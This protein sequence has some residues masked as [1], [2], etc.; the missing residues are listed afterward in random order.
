MKPR[1]LAIRDLKAAGYVFD[2]HG[3][4][5]DLYKNLVTKCKIPLKRHD[6]NENDRRYIQSEIKH[7]QR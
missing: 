5:H 3:A 2:R 1:D 7:N 6:F 4:N